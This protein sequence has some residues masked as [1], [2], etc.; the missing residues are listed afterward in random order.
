MLNDII[1]GISI[2]LNEEFG[3]T[4][5]IYSEE[6]DQN[7]TEKSFFIDVLNPLIKP[8]VGDRHLRIHPFDIRFFPIENNHMNEQICD[9]ADRLIQCLKYITV[10]GDLVRGINMQYTIVD[11]VLHFMVEYNIIVNYERNVDT[12]EDLKIDQRSKG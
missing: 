5:T 4:Y 2:K 9:V 3:D 12:M 8:Y 7:F 11:D 10:R 6:V 1:N